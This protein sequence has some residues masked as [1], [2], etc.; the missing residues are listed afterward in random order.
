MKKKLVSAMLCAAMVAT[1][2]PGTA[3]AADDATADFAGE[4]LS[5]LVSTG[6]MDNRY[7]ETIARFEETYDVTVDLQTIPIPLFFLVISLSPNLSHY[8]YYFILSGITIG[9][10]RHKIDSNFSDSFSKPSIWPPSACISS[11]NLIVSSST[12]VKASL[13]SLT[14]LFIK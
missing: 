4:E 14:F 13:V 7:D 12:R 6:W 11:C 5:I 9:S 8:I 1:M 2:V 10:K 3:M